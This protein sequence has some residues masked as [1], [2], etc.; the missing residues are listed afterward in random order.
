[1]PN[2]YSTNKHQRFFNATSMM[3]HED[4][5]KGKATL[6]VKAIFMTQERR[7]RRQNKCFDFRDWWGKS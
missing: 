2:S 3:L 5:L 1:M 4:A 6:S 7:E